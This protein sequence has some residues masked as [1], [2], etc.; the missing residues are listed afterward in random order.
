MLRGASSSAQR[1]H[2]V[3]T[4]LVARVSVFDNKASFA[5]FAVVGDISCG[6]PMTCISVARHEAVRLIVAM[7]LPLF[8]L[9][10]SSQK[11]WLRQRLAHPLSPSATGS[12]RRV[13]VSGTRTQSDTCRRSRSYRQ[14]SR[15]SHGAA[16]ACAAPV[17]QS[18]QVRSVSLAAGWRQTTLQWRRRLCV[19][20]R[21]KWDFPPSA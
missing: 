12:E 20:R 15:W 10:P 9:S 7:A 18:M 5:L 2:D 3:A 8:S 4:V 11:E 14:S 13:S 6:S 16:D 1:V 17:Y 19:R 21:R